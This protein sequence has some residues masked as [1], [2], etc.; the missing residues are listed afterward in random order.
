MCACIYFILL[1]M[2]LRGS[3][4]SNEKNVDEIKPISAR[5]HVFLLCCWSDEENA[6]FSV[7]V[8]DET[9]FQE[10]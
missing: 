9:R 3:L 8:Q 4:P 6:Y 5:F 7:K 2:C 1:W 10:G